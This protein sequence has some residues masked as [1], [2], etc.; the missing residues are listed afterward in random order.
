[1]EGL[2]KIRANKAVSTDI[3]ISN[4]NIQNIILTKN[5]IGDTSNKIAI[6]KLTDPNPSKILEFI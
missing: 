3:K 2:I 4:N 6:I 5:I 1:M